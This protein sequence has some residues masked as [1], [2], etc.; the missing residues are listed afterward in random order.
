MDEAEEELFLTV[1]D[2]H[3]VVVFDKYA[4]DPEKNPAH[5]RRQPP[6][7]VTPPSPLRILQGNRTQMADPHGIVLDPRRG[8]IFVTNWGPA[9]SGRRWRRPGKR[10]W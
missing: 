5:A 8:E 3:A 1:Q 7:G 2:D 9:T 6:P 4:T 10:A